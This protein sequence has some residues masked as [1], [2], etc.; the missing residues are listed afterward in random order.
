VIK[1]PVDRLVASIRA[2]I[3]FGSSRRPLARASNK[4]ES[5][6]REKINKFQQQSTS[7]LILMDF[8]IQF[9]EKRQRYYVLRFYFSHRESRK[10]NHI[11][12][13]KPGHKPGH[14]AKK[15]QRKIARQK[16]RQRFKFP[17]AINSF[18]IIPGVSRRKKGVKNGEYRNM[19]VSSVEQN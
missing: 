19:N 1:E 17:I 12:R 15:N 3:T 6:K 8:N 13:H 16:F 4:P 2:F 10:A 14:K 18:I 9:H 5:R 11:K 7:Q